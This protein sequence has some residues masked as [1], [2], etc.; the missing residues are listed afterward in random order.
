MKRFNTKPHQTHF[1]RQSQIKKSSQISRSSPLWMVTSLLWGEAFLWGCKDLPTDKKSED[2]PTT[3]VTEPTQSTTETTT[4]PTDPQNKGTTGTLAIDLPASPAAIMAFLDKSVTSSMS[5]PS[6]SAL[7]PGTLAIATDPQLMDFKGQPC[8]S[9]AF[10]KDVEGETDNSWP[11][12]NPDFAA[13]RFFC[14]LSKNTFAPNSVQGAYY[15]DKGFLC[16]LEKAGLVFDG[17]TRSMDLDFNDPV[18]FSDDF[19]KF[20]FEDGVPPP[21]PVTV[22]ASAPSAIA[23]EVWDKSVVIEF[24]DNKGTFKM[25]FKKTDTKISSAVYLEP[26]G[27]PGSAYAMSLDAQNGILLIERRG[28]SN[29]NNSPTQRAFRLLVKGVVEN[30]GVFKSVETYEGIDADVYQ[31]NAQTS[32]TL[33]SI[34]GRDSTGFRTFTR[35]CPTCSDIYDPSAY[36]AN[37]ASLKCYPGKD[38]VKTCTEISPIVFETPEALKFIPDQNR[39]DFTQPFDWIKKGPLQ[40]TEVTASALQ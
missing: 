38:G 35:I 11:T 30:G 8:T 28:I 9:Y 29:K 25:V 21:F 39:A 40:F 2:P 19:R 1:A 16:L 3:A 14:L 12:F 36:Q 15:Q 32:A 33:H 4:P 26:G 27:P 18:C 13:G 20:S 37:S 34:R 31:L 22:V 5:T 17:Q 24:P 23:P 6:T 10:P 7:N